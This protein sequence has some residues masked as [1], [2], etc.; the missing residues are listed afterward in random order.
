M[1]A[2]RRGA[3]AAT[4]TAAAAAAEEDQP[5]TIDRLGEMKKKAEANNRGMTAGGTNHTNTIKEENTV[6]GA[7][8]TTGRT[9]RTRT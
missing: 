4:T 5:E 8:T 2:A 7:G 9:G 3:A 1:V 6:E